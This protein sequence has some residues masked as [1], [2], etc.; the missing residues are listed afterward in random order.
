LKKGLFSLCFVLVGCG[1]W[2]VLA[3]TARFSIKK[4]DAKFD[5]VLR[6]NLHSLG[7]SDTDLISSFHQIRKDDK[8]EWITHKI[9]LKGT[10]KKIVKKLKDKLEESGA[11]VSEKMEEGQSVLLVK[12]GSRVYQEIH[13]LSSR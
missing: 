13:L 2:L 8:G 4:W 3:N 12:R 1:L 6:T 11:Q 5:T 9:S 7:L 10:N